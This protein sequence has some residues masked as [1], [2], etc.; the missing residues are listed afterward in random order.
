MIFI[1]K[2]RGISLPDFGDSEKRTKVEIDN[3][4]LLSALWVWKAKDPSD[5]NLA[6]Q[7]RTP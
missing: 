3:L 2:I 7:I 5:F 6:H 1:S 4:V